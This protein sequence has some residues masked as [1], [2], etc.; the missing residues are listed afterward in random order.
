[1]CKLNILSKVNI[2]VA[3]AQL[4]K[5]KDF[6]FREAVKWKGSF[7]IGQQESTYMPKVAEVC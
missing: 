6:A 5:K 4:K 3:F 7:E 2:K 1:M